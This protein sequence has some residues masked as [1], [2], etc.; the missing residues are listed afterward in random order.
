LLDEKTLAAGVL[1]DSSLSVTD[2]SDSGDLVG[3]LSDLLGR[4][5]DLLGLGGD[6]L[7]L[8]LDNLLEVLDLL[9]Q[10][11]SSSSS[12]FL[13][14]LLNFLGNLNGSLRSERSLNGLGF[15]LNSLSLLLDSLDNL[16]ALRD[17]G[18]D[19]SLII[20]SLGLL[21]VLSLDDSLFGLDDS[22]ETGDLVLDLS[23]LRLGLD[24]DLLFSKLLDL[25]LGV[26]NSLGAGLDLLLRLDLDHSV[27][28]LLSLELSSLTLNSLLG[29]GDG[30]S[31][32]KSILFDLNNSVLVGMSVVSSSDSVDG[33]SLNL[34]GNLQR[35]R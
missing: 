12:C 23:L 15:L 34:S 14:S 21:G 19:D 7:L 26:G 18:G 11:S 29:L 8:G 5:N 1:A 20:L 10:S 6:L 35:V 13:G 16:L 32:S 25:L 24:D 22:L 3:G 31:V 28:S 33:S 17:L 27:R 9:L 2:L 30:M 4:L